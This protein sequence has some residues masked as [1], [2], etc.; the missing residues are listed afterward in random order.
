MS[1]LYLSCSNLGSNVKTYSCHAEI[2]EDTSSFAT[3]NTSVLDLGGT[4]V[5]VHLRQLQL[6]LGAGALWQKGVAD[7]V[8]KCLSEY[9]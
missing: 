7:D 2:T 9:Q 8:A 3:S 6:S 5:A 1:A 4:G